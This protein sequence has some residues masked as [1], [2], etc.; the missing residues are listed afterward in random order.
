M[1][2]RRKKL[3][4]RKGYPLFKSMC[5]RWRSKALKRRGWRLLKSLLFCLPLCAALEVAAQSD[6]R[7]KLDGPV[8]FYQMTDWDVIVAATERSLYAIDAQTG[9]TLWRR[10]ARNLDERDVAPVP[11]TDL[12]L[13]SYAEKDRARMEALD[14]LSG[15]S[16]WRSERLRGQ[17]M[18]MAV[19][20]NQRLLAVTVVRKTKERPREGFKQRPTVHLLDLQTGEERWR[21]E[22]GS[23]IEMLP[24]RWTENEET[25]YTLDN[26]RAP[27]FLDGRLYLFYDGV[28]AYDASTGKELLRERF[29]VNEEGL[30]LTEADP[31]FDERLLYVSGRGRVRAISRTTGKVVWETKDLGT[32]PEI[33]VADGVL[34]ARTGG[35]FAR[36]RDGAAVSRGPY[37]VSAIDKETGR[38]LWQYKGADR[39]ITN[40]VLSDPATIV[41]A[42]RDDL[43]ALDAATG[44]RLAK[45]PH[46]I[47]DAAFAL[48]NERG[49]VLVGGKNEI[50]AFDPRRGQTVWRARY[51]PPGRGLLR[52]VAAIA[53]RAVSFYFRYGALFS[54]AYRGAQ[55]ARAASALRWSGLHARADLTDLTSLVTDAARERASSRLALFGR[56]ANLRGG[57]S[58]T[59]FERAG[60]AD[61]QD[62]LLDR[63]DPTRQFDRLTSFL[64]RRERLV[65]L[66]V[67]WIYFYT[68]MRERGLV[69][70]N[71]NTGRAERFVVMSKVDP[72]FIVNEADGSIIIADD[73]KLIAKSYA[74]L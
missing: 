48:L 49:H 4:L 10:R 27:L 70:V 21:R 22:L 32:T 66:R 14:L 68:Q 16:V 34:F 43:I 1:R 31:V 41:V 55:F 29:R 15:E 64:R 71:I 35:T 50:A 19:D 25:V 54:F 53:A 33:I 11:G 44:K 30:A 37:G 74:L 65:A 6:W 24:A 63:L 72:R 13:L 26:Y 73:D 28:T 38:T 60:D 57:G 58:R 8:R 67:G 20:L 42:D 47:E 61:L 39:G 40:I 17:V 2:D 3:S 7:A 56:A 5:G 45:V 12:I 52:T 36:V 46:G 51:T 59:I 18:Q 23:E 9:E 69:G 62:R